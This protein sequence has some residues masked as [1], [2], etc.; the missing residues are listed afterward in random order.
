MTLAKI[1][2][3]KMEYDKPIRIC[4]IPQE[5]FD[6]FWQMVQENSN[7]SYSLLIGDENEIVKVCR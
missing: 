2:I 4:D 3:H 5:I 1:F 6:D 7:P